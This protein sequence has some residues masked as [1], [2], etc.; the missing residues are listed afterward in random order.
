MDRKREEGASRKNSVRARKREP[1]RGR[2]SATA[3]ETTTSNWE[4]GSA[5]S[6]SRSS[7]RKCVDKGPR[8]SG[9]DTEAGGGGGGLAGSVAA[10]ASVSIVRLPASPRALV[11]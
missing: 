9:G 1:G 5:P 3:L 11:L 4:K 7:D 6:L 2:T 10:F 8:D